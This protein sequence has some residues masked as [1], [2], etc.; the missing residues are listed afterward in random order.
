M[1]VLII[2][3]FYQLQYVVVK[4]V[5]VCV[6]SGSR[7]DN[8]Q[9]LIQQIKEDMA[10]VVGSVRF[11]TLPFN[12]KNMDAFDFSGIDVLLLCHSIDNRGFSLTNVIGALYDNFLPM[13]KKFVGEFT[14]QSSSSTLLSIEVFPSKPL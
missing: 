6:C 13:A 10:D 8:V 7:S 3:F 12:T 2:N 14:S 1:P 9:G 5:D 4:K 11:Q